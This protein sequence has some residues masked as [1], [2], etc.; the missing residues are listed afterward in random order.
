VILK[1]RSSYAFASRDEAKA[2]ARGSYRPYVMSVKKS[3]P[4]TIINPLQKPTNSEVSE[5]IERW[6]IEDARRLYR[7][8]LGA[9]I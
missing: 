4:Q 3:R 1:D 8:M 5:A 9:E 6:R 7:D 2:F